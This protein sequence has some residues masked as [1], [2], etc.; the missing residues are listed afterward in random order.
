[1]G[2]FP[3]TQCGACCRGPAVALSGLPATK[4]GACLFLNQDDN[5]CS[6]YKS[7]PELC[8]IDAMR[9]D[10]MK[11]KDWY[12]LNATICNTLQVDQDI[13]EDMRVVMNG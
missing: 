8:N 9:P 10:R 1:M 11:V 2:N 12:Q 13:G 5:S 6:V 4:T 7:R 3:C